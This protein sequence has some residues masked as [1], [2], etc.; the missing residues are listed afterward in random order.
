MNLPV[1][2]IYV[3]EYNYEGI[4]KLDKANALVIT[5]LK[6]LIR[7]CNYRSYV[8]VTFIFLNNIYLQEKNF[9]N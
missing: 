1:D 4:L 9:K 8:V 2:C 6:F 3:G 5:K 7:K